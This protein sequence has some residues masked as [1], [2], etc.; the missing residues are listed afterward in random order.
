M[1][2]RQTERECRRLFAVLTDDRPAASKLSCCGSYRTDKW[3]VIR[4][5]RCGYAWPEM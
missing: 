5:V 2:D 4:S 3:S 1:T